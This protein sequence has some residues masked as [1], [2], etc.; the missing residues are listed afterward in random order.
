[1]LIQE[2]RRIFHNEY[3]NDFGNYPFKRSIETDMWKSNAHDNYINLIVRVPGN[4][5]IEV[6][7]ED[8]REYQNCINLATKQNERLVIS[9]YIFFFKNTNQIMRYCV[10]HR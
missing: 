5:G 2:Q 8:L 3:F 6:S 7:W 9:L 10:L 1:M 4:H